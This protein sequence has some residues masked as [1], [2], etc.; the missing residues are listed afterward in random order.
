[1]LQEAEYAN[2]GETTL[3]SCGKAAAK[4]MRVLVLLVVHDVIL[5]IWLQ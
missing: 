1:M 3:L 5:G 4:V 2:L